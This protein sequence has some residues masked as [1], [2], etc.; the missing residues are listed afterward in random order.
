MIPIVGNI[1]LIQPMVITL[2]EEEEEEE[3]WS[4]GGK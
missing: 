3:E 4:G 2:E 1:R